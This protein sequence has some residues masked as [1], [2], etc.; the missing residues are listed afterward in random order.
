MNRRR[1]ACVLWLV[2]AVTL[3]VEALPGWSVALFVAVILAVT[4]G[5][6]D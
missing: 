5:G 3:G 6:S 1:L 2:A 4:D